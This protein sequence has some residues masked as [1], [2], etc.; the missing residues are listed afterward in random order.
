MYK[1]RFSIF[2]ATYNRCDLLKQR[3][4]ELL[5]LDYKDFE[6]IIVSDGST[7]DTAEVVKSFINES[8]IPIKF[9]DKENGGKHT[10]WIAA[11]P[12][13]DGRYVL[14]ADDDD[15][16]LQNTLSIF[17]RYWLELEK[18]PNYHKFW[19]VRSRCLRNDGTLVGKPLPKP[20]FDSDYNEINYLYKNNCEMNGCRKVEVLK[21]DAAVP[22][23]FIFH[24]KVS[25]FPE[26]IRWSRA[27]KKYK[28]RFIP[29]ITRV[30]LLTENSLCSSNSGKKRDLRKTYN[31]IVGS[32]YA[33]IEQRDLMYKYNKKTYIKNIAILVYN[34]FN[35]H[36]SLYYLMQTRLDKSLY[37]CLYLPMLL[38][39]LVRK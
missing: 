39:N 20:Y 14:T 9:V 4:L 1:Y 30:Y 28:T 10:A 26:D 23:S 7:D 38:L 31:T 3:Y 13:F 35:I 17:N 37:I 15:V 33:L 24:D 8:R 25:N 36:L 34:S 29:D 16:I 22:T 6:W 21:Q 2:T 11:T 27:A 12:L 18:S 32:Y 19:E 5:N